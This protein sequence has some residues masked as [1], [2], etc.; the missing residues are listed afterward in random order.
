MTNGA[1]IMFRVEAIL[2][3][4]SIAMFATSRDTATKCELFFFENTVTAPRTAGPQKGEERSVA[5]LVGHDAN[6]IY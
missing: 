5:K 4:G 3:A 1:R 6:F 2:N